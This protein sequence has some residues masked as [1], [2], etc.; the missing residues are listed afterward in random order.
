MSCG[1]STPET[2][3]IIKYKYQA[4][5]AG[6]LTCT[7]KVGCHSHTVLNMFCIRHQRGGI[8]DLLLTVCGQSLDG[9]E[10]HHSRLYVSLA[11]QTKSQAGL[12]IILSMPGELYTISVNTVR[13]AG[14]LW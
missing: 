13:R 12:R 9:Y 11:L 5:G 6:T 3:S 8:R 14:Q 1:A 7:C 10:P 4:S 2:L